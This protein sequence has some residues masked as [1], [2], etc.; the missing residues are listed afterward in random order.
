MWR[1]AGMFE[2]EE[3]MYLKEMLLVKR[4]K[5]SFDR[6]YVCYFFKEFFI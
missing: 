3:C 5:D 2:K 4:N 6:I 1:K